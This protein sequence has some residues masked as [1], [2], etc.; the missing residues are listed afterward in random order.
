MVK[1]D[2]E[3]LKI[4]A[5]GEQRSPLGIFSRT[6]PPFGLKQDGRMKSALQ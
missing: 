3:E 1:E 5:E 2:L 4:V 6:S